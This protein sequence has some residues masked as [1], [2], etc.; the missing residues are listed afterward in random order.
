MTATA[1]VSSR[2][3]IG[4]VAKR[5]FAAIRRN[6]GVFTLLALLFS[7]LPQFLLQWASTMMRGGT[8]YS[9]GLIGL[10][11]LGGVLIL[12]GGV[13][14]QGALTYATVQDQNNRR[15]G[16]GEILSKGLAAVLPLIGLA[17]V[18]GIA[19]F[20][21]FLLLIVPGVIMALAWSVATPVL[22]VERK[23]IFGSMGRS[24]DLTR[25][26]RGSILLL[27]IVYWVLTIIAGLVVGAIIAAVFVLGLGAGAMQDPFVAAIEAGLISL[28]QG[29]S[30]LI[31]AA[32][33]AALYCE[34]RAIKEGVGAQTL[35]S[36]F[37]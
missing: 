2:L 10:V 12:I 36:V 1:T 3:E 6:L 27:A 9:S 16:F 24:A 31:G 15:A 30:S 7:A 33:L 5:T 21:G 13:L 25:N 17:I 14:L 37:D 4:E 20:C 29:A 11:G 23:G 18:M 35:A 22:V 28:L 34:L 8:P 19:L 26:Y 32:G